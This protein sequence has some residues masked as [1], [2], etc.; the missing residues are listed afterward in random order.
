MMMHLGG[1][2]L[3][4]GTLPVVILMSFIGMKLFRVDANIVALS[5]IAIAIGT[6][7]DMG[8]IVTENILRHLDRAGP[9]E[10]ALD[11]V[12]RG[13]TEVSGAVLTAISTTVVSFLPVFVMTGSEGKLFRPLAFTKTFALVA[14][15]I[16]A[17]MIIPPL[18][19]TIL[20]RRPWRKGGKDLLFALLVVAGVVLGFV[21]T[22]W[23]GLLVALL[24]ARHFVASRLERRGTRLPSYAPLAIV[25][26]LVALVLT[27]QWLPL[28][29]GRAFLPNF[30][31]V[32]V[33]LGVLLTGFHVFRRYYPTMLRWCLDH[34]R[35]FILL[36]LVLVLFGVTT[37]IGFDRM[38]G[39][40]PAA[41]GGFGQRL[42]VSAVWSGPAHAFPGFGREFMPPLDEGSF[43]WMPTTMPHA[44]IGEALDILQKQD[45]AIG[46]IPEVESVVGKIGRVESALDPAPISMIET[47][48]NYRSEY[49]T[50]AAGR[51]LL[52]RY[53]RASGEFFRDEFGEL[54][55]GRRGRPYRQWREEIRSPDDIWDE[56]VRAAQIPGTT[57]A[58]KLQPIETRLVMLQS[59][60]R[61]PMGVKIKGP[62]LET[63]ER[64]GLDIERLLKQVPAVR[65]S[66]VIADR[67]VGKPY[68]EIDIDRE[69]IARH[70]ILVG[71]V[72]NVIETAIGGKRV[73]TTVEGRE[74]YGVRIRY[75]RE[76]RDRIE[77]LG[78]VLV[79]APGGAQIPLEQLAE[80]RYVRGPQAVKSEDTFLISYV[81]FDRV[82][83]YAEVDVVEMCQAYLDDMTESGE[84]TIHAG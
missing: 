36:P 29:P 17:I 21:T 75:A 65:P 79:A 15:V 3:I 62:D 80:I 58:P 69:A 61:A 44:S 48:I 39:F 63:I 22:W 26:L 56:I 40:I 25:G 50:D 4:S 59:G 45:L 1:S 2:L 47:V 54:V 7:V 16:V 8:I 73:T 42:R 19:H 33:M 6:I 28:G 24:G 55:P 41:L 32:A 76:L 37:W 11:V 9:D 13:A 72:Q 49:V 20:V 68:I 12:R 27:K 74:R 81:T 57:S 35:Q 53:D 43:L 64:V 66:T 38:F 77:T 46:S 83:S 70:G 51:R 23:V 30:V 31:L 52:F 14:S 60:M 82:P 78:T 5:G 71:N 84:L 18:A 67:V 34:K 10:N